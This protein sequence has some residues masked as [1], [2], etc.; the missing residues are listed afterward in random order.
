M[1]PEHN[2]LVAFYLDVRLG[3]MISSSKSLMRRVDVLIYI[4]ASGSGILIYAVC[5]LFTTEGWLSSGYGP[6]A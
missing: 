4:N 6:C 5:A 3:V 1:H 2:F